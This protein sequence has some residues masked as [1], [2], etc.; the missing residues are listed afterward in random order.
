MNC[1]IQII[2]QGQHVQ[3]IDIPIEIHAQKVLGTLAILVSSPP[4]ASFSITVPLEWLVSRL[5]VSKD[6][7]DKLDR[8]RRTKLKPVLDTIQQ[9]HKS[10]L[11]SLKFDSHEFEFV[12]NWHLYM[13][14]DLLASLVASGEL[15]T[16][17][18]FFG[19]FSDPLL[20][21]LDEIIGNMKSGNLFMADYALQIVQGVKYNMC[22]FIGTPS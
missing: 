18:N 13:C 15:P 2:A 4:F 8:I 12:D 7:K 19:S 1:S 6:W 11:Q 16:A 5:H 3:E 17:K 10:V 20:K 22:V 9:K 14:E 21:S